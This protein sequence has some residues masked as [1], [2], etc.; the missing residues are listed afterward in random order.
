VG[1]AAG[2]AAKMSHDLELALVDWRRSYENVYLALARAAY[3]D[4]DPGSEQT[5][6]RGRRAIALEEELVARDPFIDRAAVIDIMV[7]LT[8][9]LAAKMGSTPRTVHE[10]LF[11]LAP[12]D[13]W[14]RE[15]LER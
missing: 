1:G 9:F 6:T 14:W 11:E 15:R 4:G 12:T 8:V 3:V 13:E 10:Q 5:A 2:E 7:A